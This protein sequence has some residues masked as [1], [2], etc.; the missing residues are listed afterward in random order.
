MH[1][2]SPVK[3]GLLVNLGTSDP[4]SD[5]DYLIDI[6]AVQCMPFDSLFA[7]VGSAH[8]DL[9]QVDVAGYAEVLRLFGVPARRAAMVRYEHVHL[10]EHDQQACLEHLIPLGTR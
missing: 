2:I 8:I 1:R 9:L 4:A 10:S 6:E 3:A 5:L 7:A